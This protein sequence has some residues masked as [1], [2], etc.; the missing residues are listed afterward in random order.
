MK[1]AKQFQQVIDSKRKTAYTAQAWFNLG[2]CLLAQKKFPESAAAYKKT[3]LLNSNDHDARYNLSLAMALM[4]HAI[5]SAS[6]NT[7]QPSEN[8]LPKEQP[9]SE[10]EMKNLL[11]QLNREE[12]QTLDS[13]KRRTFSRRQKKDW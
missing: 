1:R 6:L 10:E 3:L 5:T 13:M 7:P 2:N 12:S 9:V 8:N 11:H 4:N